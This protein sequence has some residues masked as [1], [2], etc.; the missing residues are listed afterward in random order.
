[1]RDL[2][3]KFKKWPLKI[4]EPGLYLDKFFFYSN[5]QT[6]QKV[7]ASHFRELSRKSQKFWQV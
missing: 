1:M 4:L 5:C 7:P 2:A 3:K 6:S